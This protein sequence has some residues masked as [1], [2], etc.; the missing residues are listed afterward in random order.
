MTSKE[1]VIATLQFKGPDRIPIDIWP[2]PAVFKRYGRKL[3]DL[4]K[5]YPLDFIHPNWLMRWDPPKL[6]PTFKLG[7]Y[8]DEWQG[9][10]ARR[11]AA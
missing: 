1:R 10:W 9:S 7:R 11:P 3:E 6:E 4:F 2:V 8:T 5:K